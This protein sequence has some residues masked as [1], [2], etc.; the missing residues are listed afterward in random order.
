MS[1]SSRRDEV[2]APYRVVREPVAETKYRFRSVAVDRQ[3]AWRTFRRIRPVRVQHANGY[4]VADG[5]STSPASPFKVS[6]EI[7]RRT[8]NEQ[9]S[10][11]VIESV[12]IDEPH[13]GA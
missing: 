7:R 9:A 13:R 1:T 4:R 10:R 11:R 12:T 3:S 5:E 2:F 6:L 8:V